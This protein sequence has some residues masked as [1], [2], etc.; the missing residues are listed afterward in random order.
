MVLNSFYCT[1]RSQPSLEA[2][3]LC[4][5]DEGKDIHQP[6]GEEVVQGLRIVHSF[7]Y[8]QGTA[9]LLLKIQSSDVP[10]QCCRSNASIY[11]TFKDYLVKGERDWR[12]CIWLFIC[13][14]DSDLLLFGLKGPGLRTI[15]F[16]VQIFLFSAKKSEFSKKMYEKVSKFIS[17]I[18]TIP[19]KSIKIGF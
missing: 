16:L 19:R 6:M 2:I 17:N 15:Y 10:W 11:K 8:R 1:L 18:F 13:V 5:H 3:G 14:L 12:N 4:L 7:T 9:H